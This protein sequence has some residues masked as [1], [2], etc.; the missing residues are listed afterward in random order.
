MTLNGQECMA[1]YYFH[2]STSSW[3]GA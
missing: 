2:P 3:H 1:H